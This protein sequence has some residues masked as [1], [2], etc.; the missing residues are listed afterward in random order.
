MSAEVENMPVAA[1]VPAAQA[2]DYGRLVFLGKEGQ[3][4]Q[5]YPIN[6]AV[7]VLGRWRLHKL[8]QPVTK[9]NSPGPLQNLHPLTDN[10][11]HADAQAQEQS[12][13]CSLACAAS[14]CCSRTCR[15]NNQHLLSMVRTAQT[16]PVRRCS[17]CAQGQE[18]RH[19]HHAARGVAAARAARRGR[20]R[21]RVAV[22]FRPRAG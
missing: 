17:A 12:L 15:D 3:R 22:Q 1:A 14:W 20:R 8:A 4:A 11:E 10:H 19:R 16:T 13:P 7:V 18:L 2:Q 21:R 6:K 9:S 5:E